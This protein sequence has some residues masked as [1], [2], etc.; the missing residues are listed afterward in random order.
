MRTS[1]EARAGKADIETN[2]AL[3]PAISQMITE[4]VTSPDSEPR[5][6]PSLRTQSVEYYGLYYDRLLELRHPE[7][8]KLVMSPDVARSLSEDFQRLPDQ[9]PNRLKGVYKRQTD[10][11][12][13]TVVYHL[14]SGVSVKIERKTGKDS[15]SVLK[16][17]NTFPA[18]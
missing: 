8:D 14:T 12:S 11:V 18:N 10:P 13:D 9:R 17:F 6:V 2:E 1:F 16:N 4:K 3:P 15:V 7:T 5:E